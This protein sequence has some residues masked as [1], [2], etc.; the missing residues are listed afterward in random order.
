MTNNGITLALRPDRIRAEHF[1]S[2]FVCTITLLAA[3][4]IL[5]RIFE[6]LLAGLVV[7]AL[8]TREAGWQRIRRDP[9][10]HLTLAFWVYLIA[11]TAA[12][13]WE[14]P[15]DVAARLEIAGKWAAGAFLPTLLFGLWLSEHPRRRLMLLFCLYPI[16]LV[17]GAL[18]SLDWREVAAVLAGER[19]DVG[20]EDFGLTGLETGLYL[21]V[22]IWGMLVMAPRLWGSRAQTRS[23]GI[24]LG[25]W[26][27]AVALLFQGFVIVQTRSTWIILAF[28]LLVAVGVAAWRLI[29]RGG[30]PVWCR[31]AVLALPCLLVVGYL[32]W[33]TIAERAAPLGTAVAKALSAA[34]DEGVPAGERSAPA[35]ESAAGARGVPAGDAA[36]AGK[37]R[38]PHEGRAPDLE[39]TLLASIDPSFSLRLHLHALGYEL[40]RERP[41]FGYGPQD[42]VPY[43]QER[44]SDELRYIKESSGYEFETLAHLH[45]T[46]LEI[47][48]RFGIVGAA[49]Y[50]V[51]LGMTLRALWRA[52]STNAASVDQVVFFAGALGMLLL[53]QWV[54]FR[55]PY[56]NMTAFV[57]LLAGMV[58]SFRLGKPDSTARTSEHAGAEPD[59]EPS[60]E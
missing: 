48:V 8:A 52:G 37:A 13:L 6:V 41:W 12:A 34:R 10:W 50:A 30:V 56:S 44:A 16:G 22:V 25:G 49:F 19:D 23:F 57:G 60:L 27:L 32:N 15:V 33:G 53:Y 59:A 21:A 1:L 47:L 17:G 2:F 26:Y 7:A 45:N 11:R 18:L 36:G 28:F 9:L 5:G 31:G 55:Y 58:H 43:M 51:F 14:D 39:G 4:E 46:Y 29:R 24:R 20:R 42:A 35:Q 54:D 3:T 38:G 40:W